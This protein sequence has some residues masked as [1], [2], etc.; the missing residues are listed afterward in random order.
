MT[1]H[2]LFSFPPSPRGPVNPPGVEVARECVNW[3][4][5]GKTRQCVSLSKQAQQTGRARLRR[6]KHWP[7][8]IYYVLPP[9]KVTTE[10]HCSH[11]NVQTHVHI[12]SAHMVFVRTHTHT[13]TQDAHLGVPSPVS[14][15][16]LSQDAESGTSLELSMCPA[17]CHLFSIDIRFWDI[18]SRS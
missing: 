18:S 12:K 6:E 14:I 3:L 1:E 13:H 15:W 4:C 5:R 17:C 8:D 16:G 7:C 2:A 10:H 9:V 11:T